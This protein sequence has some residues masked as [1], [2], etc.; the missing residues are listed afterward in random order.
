[1]SEDTGWSIGCLAFCL[2]FVGLIGWGIY[3]TVHQIWPCNDSLVSAMCA[4]SV[5]RDD[6]GK[7]RDIE[8]IIKVEYPQNPKTNQEIPKQAQVTYEFKFIPEPGKVSSAATMR[9]TSMFCYDDKK[10]EWTTYCE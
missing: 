2:F 7:A 9:G 3:W 8:S 10:Q 4:K 6:C 5:L 1:M